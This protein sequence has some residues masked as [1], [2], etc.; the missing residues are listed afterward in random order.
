MLQLSFHPDVGPEIKEAY[1]WYQAQA[2][3]LGD[4]F[5][6]ELEL[7]FDTV[8]EMPGTWP[9]FKKGF[10]RYILSRFPFAVVYKRINNVLFVVAVMHQSR[11]PNYWIGRV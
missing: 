11:K 4:D 1:R 5:I 2:H 7:A 6:E 8:I 10:R 9:I 3:G